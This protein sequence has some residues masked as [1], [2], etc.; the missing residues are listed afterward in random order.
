MMEPVAHDSPAALDQLAC[1]LAHVPAGEREFQLL[2]LNAAFAGGIAAARAD[3]PVTSVSTV[4]DGM[5]QRIR[6]RLAALDGP[7]PP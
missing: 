4:V 2:V 6:Q 5:V 1:W 7:D 3:L